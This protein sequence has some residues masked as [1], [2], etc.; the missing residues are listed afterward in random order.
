MFRTA[1]QTAWRW[2]QVSSHQIAFQWA[3]GQS[4]PHF[5]TDAELFPSTFGVERRLQLPPE[6]DIPLF[7]DATVPSCEDFAEAATL[8][9]RTVLQEAGG[10]WR[11]L[12]PD[13]APSPG[14]PK[15]LA[16]PLAK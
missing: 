8:G 2:S 5:R 15:I 13:S 14:S 6:Q 3:L 9:I 1:A 16:A 10:T 11:S 12:R 4:K 7:G